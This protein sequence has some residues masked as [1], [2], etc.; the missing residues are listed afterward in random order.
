MH[1]VE[2]QDSHTKMGVNGQCV[3]PFCLPAICMHLW[4]FCQLCMH[5][6]SS[7]VEALWRPYSDLLE[8]VC[9]VPLGSQVW[10]DI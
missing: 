5:S 2:S 7:V 3:Q 10:R 8:L 9:N 1:G 4:V 6:W